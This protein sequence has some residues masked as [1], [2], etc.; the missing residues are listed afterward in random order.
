MR[1]VS[2]NKL[3][4]Y[5][6]PP[7]VFFLF[8]LFN[9]CSCATY[10]SNV[11]YDKSTFVEHGT[12]VTGEI[13]SA[14]NDANAI[15]T[16][17]S[18]D[19]FYESGVILNELAKETD[20]HVSVAGY[21]RRMKLYEEEWKQIEEEGHVELISHS[22]NYIDVNDTNPL[23]YDELLVEYVDAKQYYEE[24]FSTPAFTFVPPINSLTEM[25]YEILIEHGI[26]AARQGKRG[27]N[28]LYPNYGTG[29]GE[30]LNLYTIGIG[31]KNTT[32]E[33]NS[34]INQAIIEKKWLIEMWH[35]VS[36]NGDLNYQPISTEMAR[37]HL[38]Y[39]AT[40]EDNGEIWVAPFTEAVSYIYQRDFSE[41]HTHKY[42]D[43]ILVW[44][45]KENEML[46]WN[47]FNTSLSI[48]LKLPND[49]TEAT[50]LSTNDTIS[51]ATYVPDENGFIIL[52]LS[53]SSQYIC[54]Q[55]K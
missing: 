31:D 42:R 40:L 2:L 44:L 52:D 15:I 14:K 38:E 48:S 7:A 33:R 35:D 8:V 16:I 30:L 17:I 19:G 21:V 12:E 53:P 9:L 32:E 5:T 23:S 47:D 55:K 13:C 43:Q 45:E 6:P 4:R 51:K 50:I 22:W 39:L 26:L 49:W 11:P 24:T 46:P 10:T 29:L 37:E 54:L 18:D 36:P 34:W 28:S 41:L 25:G 1:Q 20:L 3:H 27:M